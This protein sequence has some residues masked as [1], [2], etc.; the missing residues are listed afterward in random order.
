[1]GSINVNKADAERLQELIH[2]GPKRAELIIKNRPYRDLHELSKVPGLGR[3]RMEDLIREG[4]V[5]L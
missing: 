2:I 4:L 5:V 1:M 3:K